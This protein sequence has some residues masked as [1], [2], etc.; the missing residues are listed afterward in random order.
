MS[1]EA[2]LSFPCP[3]LVVEEQVSFN[4]DRKTLNPISPIVSNNAVRIMVNDE[5]YVP[6][7]GLY[8][9]AQLIN[10]LSGPYKITDCTNTLT[11]WTTSE[12]KTFSL[13]I[14]TL[15]PTKLAQILVQQ[16][17]TVAVEVTEAGY[18]VLTD[19]AKIGPESRIIVSGTAVEVLGFKDQSGAQGKQIYPGWEVVSQVPR[20]RFPL[21]GDPVI[22]VTYVTNIEKCS[23]CGGTGQENDVRFSPQGDMLLITDENLLYQ[24][25]LK[26]LL[27]RIQSNPFHPGYGSTIMSRIG[28]KAVNNTVSSLTEDVRRALTTL[29]RLQT[30]QARYQ[31]VSLK[32]RLYT[33]NSVNV[34]QAANDPTT[35]IVQVVVSNASG[36]AISVPIRYTV[37]GVG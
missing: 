33:I 35:F 34:S 17:S 7:S 13:P 2:R 27:T 21:K 32:E 28:T 29:Q 23:R 22:K 37:P 30:E 20:F 8:S 10:I 18:L 12:T 1:T 6:S 26:I 19:I 15:S 3:H 11:V 25:S 9:Q 36:E 4:Q 31:T 14:G 24:A 5:F 16:L